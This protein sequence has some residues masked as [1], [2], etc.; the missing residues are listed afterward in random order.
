MWPFQKI[1]EKMDRNFPPATPPPNED[2]KEV[3]TEEEEENKNKKGNVV[4]GTGNKDGDANTHKVGFRHS[5]MTLVIAI[6]AVAL[7]GT[8]VSGLLK[9]KKP[10]KHEDMGASKA[11]ENFQSP[12]TAL[13]KDYS[14][15]NQLVNERKPA[16]LAGQQNPETKPA[17]PTA[18]PIG[19]NG[20]AL[21][22][23]AP[24]PS[25]L[26]G[27]PVAPPSTA[28]NA[29]NWMKSGIGFA[30][31]AAQQAGGNSKLAAV[32]GQNPAAVNNGG[33]SGGNSKIGVYQQSPPNTLLAGSVIPVTLITG[34]N[35]DVPGDVV[36]QVRQDIYDSVTGETLL[37]PQGSR[38]IGVYD[39]NT[40]NGQS[41]IGVAFTRI[42]FPDGNY[43]E[44]DKQKGTDSAGYPGLAD[45]VDNHTGRLV[46]AG[47]MTSLL[48]AAAQIAAGN[49]NT[50][51]N[52]TFGQLAV[53]GAATNIMNAGGD[54]L[55]RDMQI[56][57]TITVRPGI[58]FS[59]FI[60]KDLTLPAYGG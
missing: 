33:A 55:K 26:A 51:T 38:L 27:A 34:I 6:V 39:G 36:A 37:I 60:N 42:I 41:R 20:T 1:K 44:I 40:K 5:L 46:S 14:G 31:A 58:Q 25:M 48:S 32:G 53:Q 15:L 29:N 54:L 11:A 56:T 22:A 18:P 10:N 7:I 13:P 23:P 59:V 49:T 43:V 47:V 9:Q 8:F 45:K 17:A 57:P 2:K 30:I 28:A 21:R 52:S 50:S 4:F 12:A 24:T 19:A 3:A 16:A 35:S